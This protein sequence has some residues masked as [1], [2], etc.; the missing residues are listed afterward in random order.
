MDVKRVLIGAGVVV[1]ALGGMARAQAIDPI[2]VRQGGYDLMNAV[3]ANMKRGVDSG[4]DVKPFADDAAA[5]ANWG[6]IIP[7]LFP[8]GSETGHNT[9]AKPDIWSDRAGF[10]KAAA[11]F[12]AA[13]KKL[14]DA[15]KSGDKA[16]F[17]DAFK[18]TGAT[19][20]A[21][22]KTYRARTN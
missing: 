14:A 9:K 13:A 12:T 18:A 17:A 10:D 20:G 7:T 22:H 11:D 5:L 21:C 4:A 16:A 2:L 8:P 15:A 6:T 1:M 3:T 19:C